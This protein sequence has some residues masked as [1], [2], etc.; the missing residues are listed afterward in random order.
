M[1]GSGGGGGS[2]EGTILDDLVD[3]DLGAYVEET[4]TD[5]TE[6]VEE[7]VVEPVVE[8]FVEVVAE[9]GDDIVEGVGGIVDTATGVLDTATGGAADILDD[10]VGKINA[11]QVAIGGTTKDLLDKLQDN[12]DSVLDGV[13]TSIDDGLDALGGGGGSTPDVELEKLKVH[14]SRLKN[15]NRANLLANTSKG[16]GRK[17]LRIS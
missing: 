6:V 17:S 9:A 1:A 2:L 8:P 11:D 7:T 13:T 15:K 10:T 4:L 5:T 3:D 16:R 14:K 12:V